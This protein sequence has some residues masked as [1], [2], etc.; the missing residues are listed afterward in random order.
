M[1][2]AHLFVA[3]LKF[4]EPSQGLEFAVEQVYTQQAIALLL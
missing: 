1:H 4:K 2:V 3:G